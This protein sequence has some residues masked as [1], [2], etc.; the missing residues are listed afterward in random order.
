MPNRSESKYMAALEKESL[1]REISTVIKAYGNRYRIFAKDNNDLAQWVPEGDSIPIYDGLEDF[2]TNNVD[3]SVR[4]LS[5][6]FATLD[7]LG[8]LAFEFLDGKL[9]RPEAVKV[10][11]M[12]T[13][14]PAT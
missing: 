12:K 14:T 8:Y 3:I 1:F 2:S 4:T 13:A 9:I 10:I 5:E 11:Q 6:K 7:Q